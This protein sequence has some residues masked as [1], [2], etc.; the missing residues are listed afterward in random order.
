MTGWVAAFVGSGILAAILLG[1]GLGFDLTAVVY[2]AFIAGV[3]G[4]AVSIASRFSR[5]TVRAAFCPECGGTLSPNAP[6]CKHCFADVPPQDLSHYTGS[7]EVSSH[8][9]P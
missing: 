2:L 6:Y 3:G 4:L 7:V 1:I 5:G 8:K 9:Q